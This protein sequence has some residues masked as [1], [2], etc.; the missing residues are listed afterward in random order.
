MVGAEPSL[1]VIRRQ[2]AELGVDADILVE[3]TGRNT[4]PAIAAA[5]GWVLNRAPEAMLAILP[6]DHNVPD[7]AAFRAA[8]SAV[9]AEVG[10][11]RIATLGVQP[12]APSAAMGYILL[13]EAR[14]AVFEIA[15]FE[16]KPNAERA[17][18]LI[19]AGALWN[20]GVFV[21]SAVTIVEQARRFA[22]QIADAV[23]LAL[24]T[25]TAIPGVVSLGSG[26]ADAPSTA[27][28]RAV[29]ER[30]DL[31]VVAPAGFAWSDLGAWDAVFAVS[32]RDGDGNAAG[33]GVTL[34][35]ATEVYVRAG[36]GMSVAVDGAHRLI[37]VAEPH[38]VLVR[39]L[40]A[41][42]GGPPTIAPAPRFETLGEA[43]SWF[44]RWLGTAALP[45]WATLGIDPSTGA[46]R[47]AM[48]WDGAPLD[49]TFH[50]TRVQARQAFVYASASAEGLPGPWLAAA[51][52]GSDFLESRARRADG[53][54]AVRVETSG[55][56]APEAGLYD[57]AFVLLAHAALSRA[58]TVSREAA[59]LAVL[60][61]FRGLRH[62]PGFREPGPEPF[63]SNAQ[64]HLF[65]AALAWE[66]EGTD[67][68][69]G[70]LA[71]QIAELALE[72]LIDPASGAMPE[73]F[74][75]DWRPVA[76]GSGRIEPGHQFE[77]AWLLATWGRRRGDPRAEQSAGRLFEIGRRAVDPVRRVAPNALGDNLAV[78]DAHARLWPQTEHIKAAL[79]LDRRDEALE[80]ACG[81]AAF[82]DTPARGVW[83]ER[84]RP[85]GAFAHEPSPATSLYHLYLAI[86][87]LADAAR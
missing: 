37:I 10:G 27:F 17:R 33:P 21:A 23:S 68:A 29:M 5:A 69:W 85:D 56:P 26:F 32:P 61:R 1:A 58:G 60:D 62:G 76:P 55:A 19:A 54:Y 41:A 4:A 20:S 35:G 84:M 15:G 73:V 72:R 6:A 38:G 65:E 28:D 59:A 64:M 14:G 51:R 87:A 42:A 82:L 49:T 46:F 47:E 25:A 22:P 9:L 24:S 78:V 8:I 45:L 30:T 67:P 50:R 31:G 40:D 70:V 79:I 39:G 81:L 74:G 36:R 63:Q 44:S 11:G 12:T 66:I 16:E 13:G 77:W 52:L 83:R 18:A 43:A 57:H 48:T 2:L 34:A 80:A 86:K 7:D 71:D 3:P 75:A 53:G